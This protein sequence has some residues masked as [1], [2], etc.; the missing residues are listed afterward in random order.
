M[1][2]PYTKNLL[3]GISFLILSATFAIGCGGR[4]KRTS[5]RS[6]YLG[7]DFR[8]N[9]GRYIGQPTCVGCGFGGVVIREGLGTSPMGIQMGLQ[10]YGDGASAGLVGIGGVGFDLS[11]Y[12]GPV[13]AEG[14]M[15]VESNDPLGCYIPPGDYEVYT[16]P[17]GEGIWQGN[18]FQM[19]RMQAIGFMG[20]A[21]GHFL[22]FIL[23]PTNSGTGP[24]GTIAGAVIDWE[25]FSYTH[26][27]YTEAHFTRISGCPVGAAGPEVYLFN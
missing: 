15:M 19:I 4:D 10:F 24:G 18:N 16:A 20:P 14:I 22:E 26:S 27:I 12:N 11:L 8:Y 17:G 23:A 3:I 6:R 2:A 5:N 1:F 21:A 9:D 25:G 13:V 7:Y